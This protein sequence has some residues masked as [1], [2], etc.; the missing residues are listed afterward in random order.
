MAGANPH[1]TRMEAIVVARYAPLVLPQPLNSLAAD[2]YLKQLPKF[3]GE[4]D[5]IVEEHIEAF[6]SYTDNHAIENEDVWMRIFVHI[7]DGE[8][9]KWFRDFPPR[10]IIGIEALD[11]SF[12]R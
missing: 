4:G 8:A 12:L 9:R 1:R 2:G 11:D 5:I 10:S 6:Y 3:I 7:L